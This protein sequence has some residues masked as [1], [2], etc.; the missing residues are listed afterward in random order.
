M[1]EA[2]LKARTARTLKW[3]VIDRLSSQ[4]LYA[5][6][7]VVLANLLSP[8]DYGLVGAIM[9]FQAFA[10]LF[11]DSGFSYALI[12]RKQPT[13]A[14]YSTVLWFNMGLSAVLYVVL[15][16]AAPLIADLF[17][18][19]ERLV[20]LS[21]V[22]FLSFILNASAIVQTNRLMKCMDVRMVAVSNTIGLIVAAVVGIWLALAGYGAWAI[23]W[24][25]LSL[26]AVKS[27]VLW[28][29]Q[30]WFP[31]LTFSWSVLRSYFGIGSR[32]MLTSFL[33]TL[34]LNIYGFF[35]GHR[36]GMAQLG[37]YHQ[38]DKWSKMGIMSISQVLTSSF[39]P[40]L[41][42]VQDDNE[43]FLRACS[44][45]N[46][47]TSYLLFPA[48]LGLM[49]VAVSLFHMLFGDKWDA[50]VPLFR[51]LL[52][53]GIFTV[54]TGLYSNF[55]LAKAHARTIMWMEVLRDS[56]ALLALMI[57]LPWISAE[58]PGHPVWG[59][60]LLLWG[61]VV[62]AAIAWGVT[63]IYTVRLIGSG[64][65]CFIRDLLPYL[66]LTL[67]A[68]AFAALA[69]MFSDKAA[70]VLAIQLFIGTIVYIGGNH[71][72]GSKIQH[73]VFSYFMHKNKKAGLE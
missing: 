7:G 12:Q 39:L 8:D 69:P 63:L 49:V 43:R 35:I 11:I 33:N 26:A 4:V 15:Y 70:V 52:L 1:A 40:V 34:F 20:P 54:I 18:H 59:L 14:D 19:D 5:V 41:S 17:Q 23:V 60:E 65:W 27:A 67:V 3:N 22:M 9:I 30:R 57:T 68:V 56:V 48:L 47:F 13:E 24:Q 61:Q 36:V 10:S 53:R 66:S 51:L 62:A 28:L 46:R 38:G 42:S 16:F 6:T 73:D 25:T 31:Q 64:V 44:K 58:Q 21:R 72:A 55:L 50:S 29:T 2:S 37:Y 45:M 32:M 71:M